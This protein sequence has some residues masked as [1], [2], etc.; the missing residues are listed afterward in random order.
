M[1]MFGVTAL[2]VGRLK[3]LLQT[4]QMTLDRTLVV[5]PTRF[6]GQKPLIY[7]KTIR[8]KNMVAL[9]SIELYNVLFHPVTTL[10]YSYVKVV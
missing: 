2:A 1:E 9:L 4:Y 3:P 7:R 5:Q 8:Q 6:V 10:L